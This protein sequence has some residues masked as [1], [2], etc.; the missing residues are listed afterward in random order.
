MFSSLM[1]LKK[2]EKLRCLLFRR[3]KKN[4]FFIFKIFSN[5]CDAENFVP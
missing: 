5:F 3:N 4:A 1:K 2:K